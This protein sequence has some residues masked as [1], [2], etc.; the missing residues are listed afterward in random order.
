MHAPATHEPW[1]PQ[2]PSHVGPTTATAQSAPDQPA[3]HSHLPSTHSPWPLQSLAQCFTAT[4]HAAPEWPRTHAQ[5]LSTQ[6]PWPL[7]PIG[8]PHPPPPRSAPHLPA[9]GGRAARAAML[10]YPT[11]WTSSRRGP[12]SAACGARTTAQSGGAVPSRHSQPLENST[13]H[14][15][16]AE[17]PNGHAETST[18]SHASPEYP[19]WQWHT[20][21]VSQ[22]P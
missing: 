8:H 1:P 7:H 12:L 15:P 21:A 10:A 14:D 3:A 5:R 19:L 20:P 17:Q 4:S 13:E 18:T 2:P 22:R 6:M 9:G 11:P 16:C